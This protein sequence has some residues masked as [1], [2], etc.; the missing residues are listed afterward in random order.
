MNIAWN[1][2][3]RILLVA[4]LVLVSLLSALPSALADT[5]PEPVVN[6]GFEGAGGWQLGKS[7]V[8]PQYVTYTAHSGT[9]SLQLGITSGANVESFSSARQVVTIPHAAGAATLS[10]WFYAIADA[11]ATTDYMELALLSADDSAILAKP[12]L[13][14]N[15]SRLWNQMTFD[16]S[17][18]RGQTVQLYFNVYNDGLGGRAAMFLDDVS[19][20]T[21]GTPPPSPS[22][23]RTPSP[24][25]VSQCN[26]PGPTPDCVELLLSGAFNDGLANWHTTAG[27]PLGVTVSTDTYRS[28]PY[29][30]KLG[31]LDVALSGLAAAQ[32]LIAV[33]VCSVSVTLE[34]W[35]YT[36]SQPDAGT[37]YQEIALLSASGGLLFAPYR[38]RA[39]DNRWVR[40]Q[41]DVSA[42]A[43][44]FVF[45]RFAVNNDG[46]GGRTAMYVD[47]VRLTAC[48]SAARPTALPPTPVPSPT[49]VPTHWLPSPT[50]WWTP[51]VP[52]AGCGEL[53]Q[54]GGFEAGTAGWK[55][56]KNL[57][58]PALV[59][60]PVLAG[61]RALQLGA[62]AE[63]LDSYTSIRQTIA[64]PREYARTV[65]SFWTYTVAESLTGTDRQQFALL[66]PGDVVWATPWKVLE[67]ARSWQQH[68]FDLAGV[69]GQPFDLYF[70]TIN[71]GLDGRTAL[72]LDE[73]RVWGCN[74]DAFP[75][76]GPYPA[77]GD[78]SLMAGEYAAPD[79][80]TPGIR[81]YEATSVATSAAGSSQATSVAPPAAASAAATAETGELPPPQ[82][83]PT[84][85]RAAVEAL[86]TIEPVSPAPEWTE[87]AISGAVQAA[88]TIIAALAP[89]TPIAPA[90]A[91]AINAIAGE[92][93]G[94]L[95][96]TAP[97]PDGLL[98]RLTAN[99][100]ARWPLAVG[101]ILLLFIILIIAAVLT[102][103]S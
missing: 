66:G 60:D 43:G 17:A 28:A 65:I 84:E 89:S 7:P 78:A 58:M 33:P 93:K 54:N 82:V 99:W 34:V 68:V 31:S 75:V 101:G 22:V 47:D 96:T 102:R 10:F 50:P 16:L 53:T 94:L 38:E 19:L 92:A 35:I 15:D 51:G 100:P 9:H 97:K 32:Q 70:G 95:E 29:A 103:R 20:S 91:S 41:F 49:P 6:G 85:T 55:P 21:C 12:W 52:P 57:L 76:I 61:N 24:T 73:V 39:N 83:Y 42:F 48:S 30:M 11:P 71:D 74:G 44:S 40:L 1:T 2:M 23:T 36:Q 87:V 80:G 5:C 25:P 56:G 26:T 62:T 46:G 81:W 64:G 45:L 27:D 67:N 59:T 69:S 37:D 3:P 88:P 98:K 72:Y 90:V 4:M 18:W 63:N 13:S 86:T 14:H 79:D 8:P 77:A